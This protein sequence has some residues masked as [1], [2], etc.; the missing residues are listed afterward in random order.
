[1]GIISA[2]RQSFFDAQHYFLEHQSYE[3]APQGRKRPPSIP[4]R[5][6]SVRRLRKEMPVVFEPGSALMVDRAARV[7]RE[8]GLNFYISP[9][10]RNGAGPTWPKAPA[11]RSSCR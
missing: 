1:M 8:L 11:C 9:A 5:R 3:Q 4:P 6:P 2:V 7:G 10:G